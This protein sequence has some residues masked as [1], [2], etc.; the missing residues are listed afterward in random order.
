MNLEY[1]RKSVEEIREGEQIAGVS[2]IVRF[3][4]NACNSQ[5]WYVK[6]KGMLLIYR[7]KKPGKRGIMPANMVSFYNRIDIGIFICFMDMCLEHNGIGFD[8]T[9]YSDTGDDKGFM[10]NA[11]YRFVQ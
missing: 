11:A 9:L 5:P 8:K 4:P 6:N 3:A 7:C 1:D 2:N 10:L